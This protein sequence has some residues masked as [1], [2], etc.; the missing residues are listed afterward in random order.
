MEI[1]FYQAECGDAAKISFKGNDG[2]NHHIMIDA[3]YERTFRH[4]LVDEIKKII[5]KKENIDLWVISHIHDD[6]I[7]GIIK[8]L[9]AIKSGEVRDIVKN[10]Y[11]N[12]PRSYN[13]PSSGMLSEIV[14]SAKSIDQ[15]DKLYYYLKSQSKLS[16]LDISSESDEQNLFG[17][18]IQILSPSSEKL[19]SLRKKYSDHKFMALERSELD[20]ISE[21]KKAKN[22][23][24]STKLDD[25]DF[26]FWEEDDSEENGSSISILTE[27][28]GKRI[29][30]LAD[31][32]PSDVI[33]SLK[34]Q[35]Y[36]IGN[37]LKCDWVKVAHHGSKGNNSNDLYDI[38]E[39]SNYLMSVNG[40][41]KHYLPT[42]EAMARI[43]LNKNRDIGTKYSFYF[44]YDNPTL[45]SIFDVD[46]KDIFDKYNFEIHYLKNEKLLSVNL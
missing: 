38:I 35:G 33:K 12:L 15:G 39:C 6:H 25:F 9:D 3:G 5:G 44:T 32:H 13:H 11:Y 8:Y 36:S 2:L 14:S 16:S 41:N 23:D 17:M 27:L 37:K 22:Y 34:A 31:S 21:A 28:N 19:T 24:Y 29:L 45:R 20:S 26:S 18:R 4:I 30:W 1:S 42:K 40:E 46:G 7:G 10:W 43:I